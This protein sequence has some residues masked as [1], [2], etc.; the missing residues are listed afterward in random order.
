MVFLYIF[1]FF[2]IIGGE[3]FKVNGINISL[4][5]FLI[6]FVSNLSKIFKSFFSK[7]I[8]L[9]NI[10][11][12]ALS[13]F[14]VTK[15]FLVGYKFAYI[16]EDYFPFVV[17]FVFVNFFQSI[18]LKNFLSLT[19][20]IAILTSFLAFKV[21]LINFLPIEPIWGGDTFWQASKS[22]IY[23]NFHRIILK[24]GEFFNL[25]VFNFLAA[26]LIFKIPI[27][28]KRY[29]YFFLFLNFLILFFSLTRTSFLVSIIIIFIMFIVKIRKE[30]FYTRVKSF[31]SLGIVSG[32]ILLLFNS[33]IFQERNKKDDGGD[34][35]IG[36]RQLESLIALD[37]ASE[38]NYL[39]NG[40]GASFEMTYA[41]GN[42]KEDGQDLYV[43]NYYVWFILK[44]GYLFFIF[45]L[46][47]LFIVFLRK[48]NIDNCNF[49][50]II[51]LKIILIIFLLF[52]EFVN[53]KLSSFSGAF[54]YS[55]LVLFIIIPNKFISN[56]KTPFLS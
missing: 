56:K 22:L 27:F 9:F 4:L 25:F 20:Y 45:G 48:V 7:R 43:H 24:G 54:L 47:L 55:Y 46:I 10:F 40:M 8:I 51:S 18:S 36:W 31:I 50:L 23:P 21:L 1:L 32:L 19:K 34:L 49:Y 30:S 29:L 35:A 15:G 14:S 13:F 16:L 26:A 6:F 11:F 33:A 52:N 12:L 38:S 42:F 3:S 17:L 2:F 44:A 5:F 39:G 41:P 53:N 28:H 37:K